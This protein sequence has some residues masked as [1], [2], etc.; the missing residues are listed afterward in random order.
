MTDCHT[1]TATAPLS[2]RHE[3]PEK[4][5]TIQAD[6]VELETCSSR[7]TLHS[8]F[9]FFLLKLLYPAHI[10]SLP[11]LSELSPAVTWP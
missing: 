2:A 3:V 4:T 8:C 10:I 5:L 7:P 6:Q 11:F 9:F 1:N